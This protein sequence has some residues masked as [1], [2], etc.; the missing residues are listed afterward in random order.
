[1]GTDYEGL[2]AV[3][4]PEHM[5]SDRDTA[6]DRIPI[7]SDHLPRRQERQEE[8]HIRQVGLTRRQSRSIAPPRKWRKQG[9]KQLVCPECRAVVPSISDGFWHLQTA[10]NQG[11]GVDL[12]A[13]GRELRA[14]LDEF[15]DASEGR[16]G[17]VE[18]R[19]SGDGVNH[20]A[21]GLLATIVLMIVVGI[22]FMFLSLHH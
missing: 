6:A 12:E 4:E 22:V 17:Y 2:A 9:L 21:A 13:W 20:L 8:E 18:E 11:K 3:T 15:I 19:G 7:N 14:E 16:V 5:D 1:M 10:H